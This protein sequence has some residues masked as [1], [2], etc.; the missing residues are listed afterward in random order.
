MVKDK[1]ERYRTVATRHIGSS[2]CWSVGC[3]IVGDSIP[4]DAVAGGNN[5]GGCVAIVDSE[6]QSICAM[7]VVSVSI[8]VGICSQGSIG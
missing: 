6:M 5:V 4:V 1:I 2:V 3:G 8:A 7:A